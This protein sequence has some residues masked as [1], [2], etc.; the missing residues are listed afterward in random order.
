NYAVTATDRAYLDTCYTVTN[1][2]DASRSYK[3][4]TFAD[5]CTCEAFKRGGYR[6]HFAMVQA[7]RA[8]E[9]RY[10]AEAAKLSDPDYIG[11]AA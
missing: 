6:K 4:D 9:A 11:Y 2:A 8:D 5:T 7:T 1:R 10:E 3:I